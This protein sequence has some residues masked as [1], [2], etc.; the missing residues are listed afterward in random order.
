MKPIRMEQTMRW[1][2]PTDPVPLSYLKMA[3]ITGVVSSLHHIPNGEVWPTEDILERKEEIESEGLKWSVVESVPVHED[4]KARSGDHERYIENFRTTLKNLGQCGIQ[5]VC[6][7]F[8]PLLDWTRTDLRYK[9]PDGS[10]ALAF[11]W[12]DL[13]VFDIYIYKRN[14]AIKDY[15]QFSSDELK[16]HYHNL[17]EEKLRV[18]EDNILKG[19]PGSEQTYGLEDFK[20]S[21][22]RFRPLDKDALTSNL[23]AFLTEVMDVAEELEIKLAIHPDDP[24]FPLFGIPRVVSTEEDL[25]Y[26]LK[27]VDSPSNG[28]TFC[29]GSY[30][31]DPRNDLPGMVERHGD[32]L[33]FVHLRN[34]TKDG[35]GNFYEAD[36]LDGDTDMKK[37]VSNILK[38]M[39]SRN[40][41]IPMRPDHGHQM[42][43]DLET[44]NINPGYT[45]IGRLKGLAELRG[46]EYGLL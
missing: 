40:E 6:Y 42:L 9:C 30:G 12:I 23:T 29:T 27:T 21:F 35:Q 39:K 38:V 43:D 22:Q 1:Y 17:D 10:L 31:V 46:L 28:F 41:S 25:A 8:M 34:T 13:A 7:N 11:N 3:G 24:P 37:V 19:L 14:N 26:I 20:K 15:P 32:R 45:A 4:I 44:N 2:G 33:Y 36:H 5:T 16:Q 18:L